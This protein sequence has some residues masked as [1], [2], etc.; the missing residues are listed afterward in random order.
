MKS[1]FGLA[2]F[3]KMLIG[4]EQA[5][6]KI[7]S[8]K[9]LVSFGAAMVVTAGVARLAWLEVPVRELP[10]HLATPFL[11]SIISASILYFFIGRAL[12]RRGDQSTQIPYFSYL[13]IYWLTAPLAWFY[14]LPVEHYFDE[15][16][17]MIANLLLLL[18]VATW[19]V[20]FIM[21]VLNTLGG[22]SGWQAFLI[23]FRGLLFIMLPISLWGGM[24]MAIVVGM[25][26]NPSPGTDDYIYV[27]IARFFFF[28]TP[29][30]LIVTHIAY[31]RNI[32]KEE[33]NRSEAHWDGGFT[34]VLPSPLLLLVGVAATVV[35][36]A[37]VT[38]QY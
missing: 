27:M 38:W 16:K 26:G 12:K 1:W 30:L 33:E 35:F 36:V 24:L 25:A 29:V 3:F 6:L 20:A 4:D 21:R 28:A 10:Y 13:G 19:R 5:I 32:Q 17:A 23:V 22:W 11:A 18:L 14:A 8:S 34:D 37:S 2:D 9:H 31:R 15:S 7:Y